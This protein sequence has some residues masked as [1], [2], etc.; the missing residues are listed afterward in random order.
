MAI[1]PALFACLVLAVGVPLQAAETI[2]LSA[3]QQ[4]TLQV[5]S[6]TAGEGGGSAVSA[7]PALVVV[8]NAQMRVIA[9]P[10][11][12]LIDRLAV[13]PGS[14]VRKGQVVAHLSSPQGLELQRDALQASSQAGLLQQSLKRD[15]QLFAE[16]LIPESRVQ[17]TRAA[18]AQAAAQASERRQGLALAGLA[19]GQLGGSL[20]LVAPIDGVVLEQ[21]AQLGQRVEASAPIYRIAK[22]SPLWLEVQAPLNLASR[23]REGAPLKVVGTDV[24]GRLL[25][26][27]KAVDPASQTV[28]LRAEVGKGSEQLI[29]GQAVAV[30]LAAAGSAGLR[31]P[32]AAVISHEGQSWV[33]VQGTDNAQE[34]QFVP[35]PVRVLGQGGDSVQV[36]GIQPGEKIAVKGVSGLKAIFTGV[37][38]E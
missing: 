21:S 20:A 27:G 38:K 35:R 32:A 13:A 2:R 22:L 5:V 25:A 30:E 14:R 17:A 6:Q 12:G 15:E 26:I 3:A 9:A 37:G 28:L 29:P 24:V 34:V 1:R 4:K 19:P 10:V 7:L 11:G 16:G 8:P 31:L 23:L 33:F 18:A 36:D